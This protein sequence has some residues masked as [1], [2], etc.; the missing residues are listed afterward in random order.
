Y[1]R[2]LGLLMAVVGLVLLIACIKVANLLLAR[3]SARQQEFAMR[4]ALGASRWRITRQLLTESLLLAAIAG[5]VGTLAASW[6]QDL[7]LHWSAWIRGGATMDANMDVRVLGFSV[8]ISALTGMLF[9]L[10]PAIRAAAT[11][12]AP[13][14]KAQ[15]GRGDH[16]RMLVGRLLIVLQ[17]AV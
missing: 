13:T 5:V 9:G 10:A 14:V 16:S 8:A 7:L 6:S 4:A 12:I 3:S 1:R 11:R 2:P 15:L 17:V